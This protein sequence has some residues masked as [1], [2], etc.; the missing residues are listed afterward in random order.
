VGVFDFLPGIGGGGGLSDVF[1]GGG[2][3]GMAG[4]AALAQ[5][6]TDVGKTVA[7]A[8]GAQMQRK[9]QEH[10]RNTTYQAMVKDL[11]KA[12]LNPALAFGGGSAHPGATP[13][14]GDFFGGTLQGS[15]DVAGAIEKSISS[16]RQA[17]L[18]DSEVLA[19]GAVA[20]Q[21]R[22]RQRLLPD[23]I[24]S[25]ISKNL[26]EW[27]KSREQV[28]LARQEAR[29]SVAR[30]LKLDTE[31]AALQ[32]ELPVLGA[33]NRA[34]ARFYDSEAGEIATIVREVVGSLPSLSG[35]FSTGASRTRGPVSDSS[36]KTRSG[37]IGR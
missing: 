8:V 22:T 4:W 13:T 10:M 30:T 16:A 31:N 33:Q 3:G 32:S 12:G 21:E 20:E 23:L 35:S 17:R 34:R 5:G 11:R 2:G 26:G 37:H 27:Y 7:G 24:G 9:W 19:K 25:E 36:W 18:I 6:V 28:D 15:F 1:G 29:E 14:T